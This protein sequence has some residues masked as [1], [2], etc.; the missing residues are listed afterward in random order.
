MF[1]VFLTTDEDASDL[2]D[3][4]DPT[5]LAYLGVQQL[6]AG[7]IPENVEMISNLLSSLGKAI[8]D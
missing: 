4:K 1:E 2:T 6:L 7:R 3:T 5:K 8:D